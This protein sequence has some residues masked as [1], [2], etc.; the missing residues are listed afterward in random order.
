MTWFTHVKVVLLGAL[1]L[2]SIIGFVFLTPKAI[3]G[4][5]IAVV[6]G[7]IFSWIVGVAAIGIEIN[8]HEGGDE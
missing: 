2:S 3:L 8:K 7:L 5:T 6:A 4:Y 1:I